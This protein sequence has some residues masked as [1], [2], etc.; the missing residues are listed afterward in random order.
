MN[1]LFR[2][3]VLVVAP[4]LIHPAVNGSDI[5][6]ERVARYLSQYAPFTDLI[7]CNSI[8]RYRDGEVERE[9]IFDNQLRSRWNAAI[10]T[11]LFR[12]HYLHERFNTSIITHKVGEQ[13]SMERYC[14]ILASYLVTLP[15]LP[16][17]IEARCFVWTHNDEFKWFEDLAQSSR[18][19]IGRTVARLSLQWLYRQVP[20]LA[21]QAVFIHVSETDRD[22]FERVVADHRNLTV[23]VGTD[24]DA[25]VNHKDCPKAERI[26]LTFIGTLG[27]RMALDALRH[28]HN[29]FQPTLRT[30]FREQL[31]VRVIGS[32]P[33]R[34][35]RELCAKEGWDLRANVSDEELSTLLSESTFTFLPFAYATGS[36][37]KLIRSLGSGVP[38]LSTLAARPPHFITPVGCCFS[39]DPNDWVKA[40]H[41]W[42]EANKESARKELLACAQT[43]A[44]PVV[45]EK[46]ANSILAFP[47]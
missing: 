42:Q 3:P 6:L 41:A 19:F 27:V 39:N 20:A 11:V 18:N 1:L 8:R 40:V 43:Y 26:V 24:I 30:T 31:L 10:R 35:V 13:I 32:N 12:S 29:K 2:E 34:S 37:L 21:R 25:T 36:K 45:I 28:F 5:S 15:L 17:S 23:S 7:S 22:G 14:V 16:T 46:M 33:L 47:K 9:Q 4:H 44:W 38:F